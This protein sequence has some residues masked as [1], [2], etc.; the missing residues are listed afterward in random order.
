MNMLIIDIALLFVINAALTQ[1][2]LKCRLK[3]EIFT[4]MPVRTRQCDRHHTA[5]VAAGQGFTGPARRIARS[6]PVWTPAKE[7]FLQL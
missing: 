1:T 4:L 5:W 2:W 6:S 3:F 7:G